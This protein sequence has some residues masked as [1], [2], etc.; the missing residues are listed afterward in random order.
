MPSAIL[1]H[2]TDWPQYTN[3]T[4]RTGLTDNGAVGQG[5]SFYKW[6]PKWILHKIIARFCKKK[7]KRKPFPA[8]APGG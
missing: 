7:Q 3:V 2:P 8:T 4:D 1:I 6:S 5:E